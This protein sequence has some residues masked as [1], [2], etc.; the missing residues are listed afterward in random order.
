MT[1]QQPNV[2]KLPFRD[3]KQKIPIDKP[4]PEVGETKIKLNLWEWLDYK[5]SLIGIG[6]IILGKVSQGI[7]ALTI[8]PAAVIG[9]AV[10]YAGCG[11]TGIGIGHKLIKGKKEAGSQG[12]KPWWEYL[13]L[14]LIEIAKQFAKKG[15]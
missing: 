11:M 2:Q 4:F 6:L 8:P 1:D 10:F 13:I 12:T 3:R 9:E 15:G 14:I 7:L 5:K